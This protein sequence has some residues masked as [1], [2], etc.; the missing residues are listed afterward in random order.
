VYVNPAALAGGDGTSWASAMNDLQQAV[1]QQWSAGG[2]EVWVQRGT[3]TAANSTPMLRMRAGVQI[4]GGFEGTEGS[5]AERPALVG[6][7][8]AGPALTA[9][10]PITVLN[11][12][13]VATSVVVAGSNATLDRFVVTHGSNPSGNYTGGGGISAV[14]VTGAQFID[15]L[16]E[17]NASAQD[18]GAVYSKHSS[19]HFVRGTLRGNSAPNGA[20]IYALNGGSLDLDGTQF[21][22]NTGAHGAAIYLTP[23]YSPAA[24]SVELTA[25]G[26]LFAGNET[27]AGDSSASNGNLYLIE[28]T[29]SFDSVE[30]VDN[31]CSLCTTGV[32]ASDSTV[33][34]TNSL[35][36]LN[37]GFGA[38]VTAGGSTNLTVLH[39]TFAFNDGNGCPQHCDVLGNGGTPFVNSISAMLSKMGSSGL[40]GVQTTGSCSLFISGGLGS[41]AT[42]FAS[43]SI[44]RDGNGVV[45]YLL[46]QPGANPC[47]DVGS[48]SEDTARGY[49][50]S[51]MTTSGS[52]CLD[53]VQPDAGRHYAPTVAS[54]VACQ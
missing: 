37:R 32:Y 31:F 11:G 33:T 28:A 24:P 10:S 21:I 40:S 20:G 34:F 6:G 50:W 23:T 46:E 51:S 16:L 44:D 15:V 35:A 49:D 42:P 39:S 48:A 4:R 17:V 43:T 38:A 25:H 29:A 19:L 3:F 8:Y 1:D 22:D 13:D 36:A 9:S 26:A 12:A 5:L 2:G 7:G 47:L 54:P 27:N 45:D 18:G 30:L 53:A 52:N 14:D 41:V